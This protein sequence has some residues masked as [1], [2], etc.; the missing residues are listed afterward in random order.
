[1][2]EVTYREALTQALREEMLRDESVFLM[3]EDVGRYGGSYAVT[4]ETYAQLAKYA[5][6]IHPALK[7]YARSA[8][9]IY[10]DEAFEQSVRITRVERFMVMTNDRNIYTLNQDGSKALVGQAPELGH[11]VMRAQHM[12]LFPDNVNNRARW[13]YARNEGELPTSA[14]NQADEYNR[15]SPADRPTMVDVA[16]AAGV[17]GRAAGRTPGS[18]PGC[19]T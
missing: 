18:C 13:M 9:V 17:S 5:E 15:L 8:S 19:R 10:A 2:A 14:G 6:G 4:V 3:G 16:A 7:A 1:M 11:V 12:I